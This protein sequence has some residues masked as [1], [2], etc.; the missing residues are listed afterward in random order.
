LH[1]KCKYFRRLARGWSANLEADIRKHKKDLME[2]YDALDILAESQLLDEPSRKRLE[3]I[4]T[5]LNTYWITEET[6]ARERS[7]DRNILEGDRNTAYFHA[8]ANQ[9][10]GKKRINVLEGSDGPVTDQKGMLKIVTEFYKELF[11]K[12]ERSDI[13]LMNDFFSPEEK[14]TLQENLE[15]E[16]EFSED[17]LK[18]QC[19]GLMLKGHLVLMDYLSFFPILLGHY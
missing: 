18:M 7:R 10:R 11:K 14:V 3:D 4:L 17:E 2:E 9:R 5:E 15:L 13:R 16:K 6:K 12:E 19:L 8:V 1:D